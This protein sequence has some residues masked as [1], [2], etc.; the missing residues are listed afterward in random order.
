M[1][2]GRT[3]RAQIAAI[4]ETDV[5]IV[6]TDL[7]GL[8]PFIDIANEL[9]TEC[10]ATTIQVQATGFCHTTSVSVYLPYRLEM[11]ERWLSAHFYAMRDERP[12]MQRAGSVAETFQKVI[13]TGFESTLYGQQAIRL[14]T[15]GGLAA[16]NNK[17]K[18]MR[19]LPVGIVHLGRRGRLSPFQGSGNYPIG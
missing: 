11:I 19:D 13:D 6:G 2:P 4:I 5:T 17:M 18:H 14:D 3:T 1:L 8:D 16:K 9:V 7:S 12:Q 15:N 10:C